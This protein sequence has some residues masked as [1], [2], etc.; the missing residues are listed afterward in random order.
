MLF[1]RDLS[2]ESYSGVKAV[3]SWIK[4]FKFPWR[5]VHFMFTSSMDLYHWNSFSLIWEVVLLTVPG[6]VGWCWVKLP[7]P[8]RH[9]NFGNSMARA[10]RACSSCGWGGL[11]I[12]FLVYHFSLLSPSLWE[13]ARYRLKYCLKGPLSPKQSTN[14]SNRPI[15]IFA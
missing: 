8:G 6:V 7:V 9:T 11:H 3:S 2:R 10:Y 13:T 4:M 5:Y 12:L 14:Q 1:I 15:K